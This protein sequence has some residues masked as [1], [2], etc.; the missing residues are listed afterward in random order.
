MLIAKGM[1]LKQQKGFTLIELLVV[2]SIIGVLS[3]IAMTS[4]NGARAKARDVKRMT[5]I[6]E[7]Q[8]ALELYYADNG[9]YPTPGSSATYPNGCWINSA[10]PSWNDLQVQ[11]APYFPNLPKDTKNTTGWAP[12][13]VDSYNYSYSSCGGGCDRQWYVLVYRLEAGGVTDRG[14]K[15]CD[16]TVWKANTTNVV[17]IGECKGC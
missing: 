16:G 8:K 4:L 2:I 6:G 9:K 1:S 13:S 5:E 3:T 14:V 7:I 11:L 12:W 15:R 17:S 10:Y